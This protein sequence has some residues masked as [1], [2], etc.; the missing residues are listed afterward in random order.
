MTA[1]KIYLDSSIAELTECLVFDQ[2]SMY[3]MKLKLNYGDKHPRKSL[4]PKF[5]GFAFLQSSTTPAVEVE[6]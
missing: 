2:W 3:G 6:I 1:I 5:P 4:T